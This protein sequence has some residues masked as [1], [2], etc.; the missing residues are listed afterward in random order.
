[1][2]TKRKEVMVSAPDGYHW[3]VERGRYYLMIGDYKKHNGAAKQVPFK[4]K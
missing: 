1:M 3:M 4:V 2:K